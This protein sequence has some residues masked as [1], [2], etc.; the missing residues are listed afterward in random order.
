[1]ALQEGRH[2]PEILLFATPLESSGLFSWLESDLKSGYRV[3]LDYAQ[4]EARPQ[5]VI[6]S[7]S[8]RSNPSQ[9]ESELASLQRRWEPAPILLLLPPGHSYSK[10]FLLQLPLAGIHEAPN[11]SELLDSVATLL[12]GGRVISIAEH[13]QH[14]PELIQ[15]PIGL[16]QWLLLSGLQQIDTELIYCQKLLDASPERLLPLL[17][18][19]GRERE[20]K[21]ARQLLLWLWGPVSL[22]WTSPLSSLPLAEGSTPVRRTGVEPKPSQTVTGGLA[23]CLNQR[24]ANGVWAALSTR[25]K[26]A[27]NTSLENSSGQVLALDGLNSERRVD[28]L[29]ALLDQ[30]E[31]LR[32]RLQ[33]D[34]LQGDA[35]VSRWRQQQPELRRQALRKMAGTYVQM[36]FNGTLKPVVEVLEAEGQVDEVELDLPDPL[37]ML[38]SLIEARPLLVDGTLLAPD[39]PRAVL[40]LEML[41]SNWLLRNAELISSDVLAVSAA[42]PELRRYLLRPELLSTRS[43]EK[44]RNQLNAQQ[45]WNSWFERPIELYESRR[46][47]YCLEP[48]MIA[49]VNWTE[50]RDTELRHLGWPQQLVTLVLEARDA[51]APQ[52]QSLAKRV[53]DLVVVLLT[54][55]VGRAIGLI[56]RGI[57][58]GMGRSLGRG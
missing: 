19:Q 14:I 12:N 2:G 38:A 32:Q 58:Q 35:L 57:V 21:T 30:F 43:L 17:L 51:V 33:A 20:L 16:G 7:L 26:E 31:Q 22:A 23:I 4:L 54:Q 52:L 41:L 25:L 53:G 5:L 56:G 28:L 13:Q 36:P 15:A 47:F 18:L 34:Q 8:D 49:S 44:L 50:L 46:Q 37:V 55:V 10:V 24:D 1:M 39:E 29:L 42:W 3:R 45:R 6:W 11:Q 9:L 48:G 27:L 40:Y